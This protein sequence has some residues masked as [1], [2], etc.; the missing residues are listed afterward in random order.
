[1]ALPVG[2]TVGSAVSEVPVWTAQTAQAV[3]IALVALA[4]PIASIVQANAV[5]EAMAGSA[6][7]VVGFVEAGTS[8]ETAWVLAEATA[9]VVA[10]ELLVIDVGGVEFLGTEVEVAAE[11]KVAVVSVVPGEGTVAAAHEKCEG[12]AA[13]GVEVKVNAVV[14]VDAGTAADEVEDIAAVEVGV[15]VAGG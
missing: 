3:Q 12:I 9:A 13:V 6:L 8:E 10:A 7:G 11:L 4:A 14:A 15:A 1:M 5:R 2:E